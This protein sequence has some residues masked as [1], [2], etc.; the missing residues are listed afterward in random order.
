MA[1]KQKFTFKKQPRETGLAS[2]GNPH[3]DTDIKH[4]KKLVG[5]ISS[6]N[7]SSPD[8]KWRIRLTVK[9]SE[10]DDNPNCDWKWIVLK[11]TFD[12]E[13]EAREFLNANVVEILDKNLHHDEDE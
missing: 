13:P 10:P 9:K 12:T 6:P 2:V 8:N 1:K 11:K 4:N 5:Y 3:P 7:W